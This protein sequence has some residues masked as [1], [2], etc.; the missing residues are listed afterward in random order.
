MK[1]S[2]DSETEIERRYPLIE[3]GIE[4]V[5]QLLSLLPGSPRPLS[6]ELLTGGHI[7]TNYAVRLDNGRRVVL[8]ICA[9][10][11]AIFQKEVGVLRAVA[12][13]VPVPP[14]HLAIFDP[15]FFQYPYAV[16]EWVEG[17]ALNEAL[18]A[19]PERAAEI[20]R[21][22]ASVLLR[23]GEQTLPGH[24][25][26]PFVEYIR[27]CLY[28][29]GGARY[30]GAENSSRLWALVQQQSA[31]LDQ[32]CRTQVLVH[33]DFQGDNI[34][35]QEQAGGWRVVAVLDWEWARNGC[36][37]TDIGSLLR[38]ESE[39]SAAF[40]DG[41]EA[42]FERSGTPLPERWRMAARILDMAAHCEKLAYPRHRGEVTLR[43][44]RIIERCLRDY[45]S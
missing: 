37:L 10:G 27:V 24:P 40:Q 5:E 20:G 2:G 3:I 39:A 6:F 16:L 7:N 8:R 14:L 22:V 12:G 17:A 15:Q 41:I 45:A 25:F 42:G 43:S 13:S 23:I 28:E 34:L 1:A 30:L 11:E 35:L 19:H 38:F 26:P 29:R 36:Y 33:G 9:H 44:I 21:A 18:A 32:A 4:V 31:F